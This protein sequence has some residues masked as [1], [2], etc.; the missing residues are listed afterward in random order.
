MEEGLRLKSFLNVVIPTEEVPVKSTVL[1]VS[2]SIQVYS[3]KCY[4]QCPRSTFCVWSSETVSW[5]QLNVIMLNVNV[6]YLYPSDKRNKSKKY[7]IFLWLSKTGNNFPPLSGS[8]RTRWLV[9]GSVHKG[10][11]CSGCCVNR[12][13]ALC[14]PSLQNSFSSDCGS[15]GLMQSVLLA[16]SYCAD[17]TRG[18]F[19]VKLIMLNCKYG[20]YKLQIMC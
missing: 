1:K 14:L 15:V 4:L 2:K 20:V 3:V 13:S 5:Q 17:K 9:F 16:R 6:P 7:N 18:Q 10:I 11:F 12:P 8:V 19:V